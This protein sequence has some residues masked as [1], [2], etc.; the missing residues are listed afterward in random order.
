MTQQ[1]PNILDPTAQAAWDAWCTTLIDSR[2]DPVVEALDDLADEAGA[3]NGQSNRKIYELLEIVKELAVGNDFLSGRIDQIIKD[4]R[5]QHGI[6]HKE[7]TVTTTKIEEERTS[8][9]SKVV[10]VIDS[11]LA[12]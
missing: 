11:I 9:V 10:S 4:F 1:Q 5:A 6:G 7:T 12:H 8:K 3:A 2:I